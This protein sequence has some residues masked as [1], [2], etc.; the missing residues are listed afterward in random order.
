MPEGGESDSTIESRAQAPTA[1]AALNP[2]NAV[3]ISYASQDTAVA[4]ALCEA[5]ER[6]GLAC[7]IAPRNVVPGDFY[8]D[9]I[10]Q[11]INA[12]QVLVLVLS[13]S[14]ITSPHVVRE[15][16]R[17]S[18]KKRPVI[19][20]RIDLAPLPPGLEYFLSASH[21]LDASAGGAERAFPKLVE[22]VRGRMTSGPAD[23]LRLGDAAAERTKQ[24]PQGDMVKPAADSQPQRPVG[25]QTGER[26]NRRVVVWVAAVAVAVGLAYFV[27][28]KFWLS[29]HGPAEHQT[30]SA[31]PTIPAATTSTT[32]I[33]DKS[34]AVL[35]FTDMSE[36]KDQEYFSDGLAEELIGLL[37]KIPGLHVPART[38]S[39]YFKGKQSTINEIAKALSVANVLEGSVRKS[40]NTLRITAQLIRVDNGYDVWS[41]TYDRQLD[42][43]FKVQDEIAG[44]VVKALRVSLLGGAPQS[45]APTLNSE[46]YTLYLKAK[47][48]NSRASEADEDQ[49]VEDLQQ[50][51][52][53][54]PKF[55][56]AWAL[57][58]D[59]R[60]TSYGYFTRPYVK[61]RTDAL[62]AAAQAVQLDPGLSEAHAATARARLLFDWDFEAADIENRQALALNPSNAHAVIFMA[63]LACYQG[64]FDE[65]LRLADIA[66]ARDPLDAVNYQVIGHASYRTGKFTQAE[67]AFRRQIELYPKAP[68]VHYRL[69]LVLLAQGKPVA[70]LELMQSEPDLGYRKAGMPLALDALGRET[71]ADAAIAALENEHSTS[72]SYQM[73]LIYAHRHDTER[74]FAWLDTAYRTR[75][76]GLL[77]I[78]GDPLLRLLEPDPRYHALL[79][80]MKLP[81]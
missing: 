10:V 11:A 21:W 19:S 48:L 26:P 18:A 77:S 34:I 74:A 32:E 39:F 76:S 75:D 79:R 30:T 73:A 46:A 72:W 9:A 55:A 51:L 63:F 68:A 47:E 14:S 59:V 56:L 37:T 64:R 67:A 41:E 62:Y 50:A 29:K 60:S 27:I 35:P 13:E 23:G 28:N 70:A 43:I 4:D 40:G 61:S 80:K 66:V 3:F 6:A 78:K 57:L 58:A 65:A 69:G 1:A 25:K 2:G 49:A 52:K 20:F 71:E 44:A 5:L 33:S 53:L 17:A 8:A 36:K 16:E 31:A 7:W 15:V 81:E 38:S 45:T 42:D 54:D 24:N 12:C 22:A